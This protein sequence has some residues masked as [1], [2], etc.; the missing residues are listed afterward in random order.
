MYTSIMN[1][2]FKLSYL[3]IL[4]FFISCG[5]DDDGGPDGGGTPDGGLPEASATYSLDFTTNFTQANNPQDYPANASFGTIIAIAHAPEVSVYSLGQIAS[6]GMAL[7]AQSGDVDGLA[8]FISTSLGEEGDGLF[9]I[10]TAGM[11]GPESSASTSVSVT[12]TRT[13]ITFLARLNPSPDWFLGVSSFNIVDGETLIDLEEIELRPI[14]AGVVLGDTYEA[15]DGSEN[16]AVSLYD[17]APF[18]NG[19]PLSEPIGNL[20][21]ERTN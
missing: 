12:P 5:S 18:G 4:S 8:A 6:D 19:D 2:L 14:D 17:G 16:A 20:V 11:V 10:T 3:V 9:S 15:N 1:K 13:R 21:I 7:Y